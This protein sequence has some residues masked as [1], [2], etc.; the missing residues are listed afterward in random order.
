MISCLKVRVDDWVGGG[1]GE[2]RRGDGEGGGVR[3]FPRDRPS[4]SRLEEVGCLS[5]P[6]CPP[7]GHTRQETRRLVGSL[8]LSWVAVPCFKHSSTTVA[9]RVYPCSAASS[10]SDSPSSSSFSFF[11]YSYPFSLTYLPSSSFFTFLRDCLTNV[12]P[13]RLDTGSQ[14]TL[15]RAKP[16]FLYSYSNLVVLKLNINWRKK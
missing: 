16:R 8:G 11:N 15:C 13:S 14:Y 7:S 10:C 1:G 2:G 12:V 4:C 6:H 5:L 9:V 3:G